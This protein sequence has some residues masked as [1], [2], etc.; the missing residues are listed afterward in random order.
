[1]ATMATAHPQLPL[2]AGARV[3]GIPE[4]LEQ[5]LLNLIDMPFSSEVEAQTVEERD[6]EDEA[7][8]TGLQTV[9]LSQRTSQAFGDTIIGSPA[10]R[11]ALF[12]EDA[13]PAVNGF[14]RENHLLYYFAVGYG[15]PDSSFFWVNISP[16][17]DLTQPYPYST[18]GAVRGYKVELSLRVLHQGPHR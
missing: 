1:M 11:R 7:R 15:L 14:P 9:L 3:A 8:Y 12:C 2:S 5:I 10:I 13:K 18:R 6:E 16:V 17:H 4:L